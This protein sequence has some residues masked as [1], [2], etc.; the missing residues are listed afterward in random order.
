[1]WDIIVST[2]FGLAFLSGMFA[3]ISRNLQTKSSQ[4]S[5]RI[6]LNA[7]Y[8]LKDWMIALYTMPT[9][10]ASRKPGFANWIIIGLYCLYSAYFYLSAIVHSSMF[11]NPDR[12]FTSSVLL[13]LFLT[14][15]LLAGR[16]Y[17][18]SAHKAFHGEL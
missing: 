2:A 18:V 1:M 8:R 11:L 6:L 15:L 9:E 14:G 4:K 13:V 16:F 17:Q 3:V 5:L 12:P 7:A 10:I